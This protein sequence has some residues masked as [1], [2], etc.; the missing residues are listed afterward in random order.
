MRKQKQTHS[1]SSGLT[2]G[3]TPRVI[4][5]WQTLQLTENAPA[6]IHCTKKH[7]SQPSHNIRVACRRIQR[8]LLI[9]TLDKAAVGNKFLEGVPS[10]FVGNCY[11]FL[12]EY[13]QRGI[14]S[15][16]V[17]R[18]SSCYRAL[19]YSR[20]ICNKKSSTHAL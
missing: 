14:K 8:T 12:Q 10:E 17:A 11:Y 4:S 9:S 15:V 6:P 19:I 16:V 1:H 18:N 7:C 13:I 2:I 3:S 20:I 5:S